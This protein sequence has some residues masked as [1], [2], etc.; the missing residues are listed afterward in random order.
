MHIVF[1]LRE[2]FRFVNFCVLCT[3][4]VFSLPKHYAFDKILFRLRKLIGGDRGSIYLLVIV[5]DFCQALKFQDETL[6]IKKSRFCQ[7]RFCVTYQLRPI[8]GLDKNRIVF[9]ARQ[10]RKYFA[11]IDWGN[12]HMR[13]YC[14]DNTRR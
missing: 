7:L 2:I 13:A 14:P 8:S 6:K 9:V 1:S 10:M 5:C 4:I 11:R 3:H 12:K